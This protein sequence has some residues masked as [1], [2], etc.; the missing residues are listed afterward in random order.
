MPH[1]LKSYRACQQDAVRFTGEGLFGG[2]DGSV[3]RNRELMG[4]GGVL[5]VGNTLAPVLQISNPVGGPL[6]SVR[7]EAVALFCLIQRLHEKITVPVLLTIL[8]TACACFNVCLNGEEPTIG[9]DQKKSSILMS[10]FLPKI[11]RKWPKELVLF[12]IKSHAGC[13][14]NELA[15]EQAAA[16]AT[17]DGQPYF[18]RPQKYGTYNCG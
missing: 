11:L 14:H 18:V 6:A 2:C 8:S 5:T 17:L 4:A 12:K 10:Y 16:C 7:P 13:Y 15:D 9:Q 3:D 1:N